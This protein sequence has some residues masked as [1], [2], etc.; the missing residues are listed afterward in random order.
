MR[1]NAVRK[2]K[3]AEWTPDTY[4]VEYFREQ[5]WVSR[6]GSVHEPHC[7]AST[8]KHHCGIPVSAADS[9]FYILEPKEVVVFKLTGLPPLNP[10]DN[11]NEAK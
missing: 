3:A 7:I 2:G 4:I 8:Y 11:E 10:E 5:W 9:G 1:G 6:G